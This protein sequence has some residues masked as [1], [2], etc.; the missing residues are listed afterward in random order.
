MD[1]KKFSVAQFKA[2]LRRRDLPM[3]GRKADLIARL[4]KNDTSGTW[5]NSVACAKC[6]MTAS[7]ENLSDEEV[8][9]T[10]DEEENNGNEGRTIE[11]SRENRNRD[12]R[13][14][15]ELERRYRDMQ[16]EF[17][18]RENEL[19]RRELEIARR[20]NEQL[21]RATCSRGGTQNREHYRYVGTS[22]RF[23]DGSAG[24]FRKWEQQVR[25]LCTTYRLDDDRAKLLVSNK[26]KGKAKSWFQTE[27]TIAM[28]LDEIMNDFQKMYR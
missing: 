3:H 4:D 26:I 11:G 7:D 19:L 15:N 20:E 23:F 5:M 10:A 18:R 28:T 22:G 27:N 8:A 21:R 1:P 24:T 25:Q 6:P 2:E 12:R 17:E 14:S 16:L 9:L 13:N